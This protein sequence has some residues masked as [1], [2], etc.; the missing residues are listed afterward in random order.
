MM[1]PSTP[2]N[3]I[4]IKEEKIMKKFV[5]SAIC[6]LCLCG[7]IASMAANNGSN[8]VPAVGIRS[9]VGITS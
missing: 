6:G 7:A 3:R 2:T 4:S 8:E 1:G 5:I 9:T